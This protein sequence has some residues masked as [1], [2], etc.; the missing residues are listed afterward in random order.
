MRGSR[1]WPACR[2][3][4]GL[5]PPALGRSYPIPTLA[6]VECAPVT[7]TESRVTITS[8]ISWGPTSGLRSSSWTWRRWVLCSASNT[9]LPGHTK[10]ARHDENTQQSTQRRP[11]RSVRLWP[12]IFSASP[13]YTDLAGRRESHPSRLCI[14]TCIASDKKV[15]LAVYQVRGW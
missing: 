2:C 13:I 4:T 12:A 8:G 15:I 9:P 7:Q 6:R 3:L 11:A 1:A 14:Q 5:K 10:C